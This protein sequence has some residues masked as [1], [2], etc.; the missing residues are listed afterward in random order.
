MK[1]IVDGRKFVLRGMTILD[2]NN[3]NKNN[4]FSQFWIFDMGYKTMVIFIIQILTL[5]I[6]TST[7]VRNHTF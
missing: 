1:L 7:M 4:L 5:F 3:L 2:L 6:L